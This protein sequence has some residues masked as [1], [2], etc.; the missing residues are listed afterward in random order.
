MTSSLKIG[1]SVSL[2]ALAMSVAPAAK[3]D[4]SQLPQCGPDNLLESYVTYSYGPRFITV[5]EYMCTTDGWILVT[6]YRCYV[7]SPI[8]CSEP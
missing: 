8:P 2:L 7:D 6:A 5:T 4:P 3:A 1:L